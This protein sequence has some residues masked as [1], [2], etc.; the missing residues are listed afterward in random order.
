MEEATVVREKMGSLSHITTIIAHEIRNPL[1]GLNIYLSSLEDILAKQGPIDEAA[2][3]RAMGIVK[4]MRGVS[5]KIEDIVRGVLELSRPVPAR[6]NPVQLNRA[7]L[8]AV[9]LCQRF[10]RRGRIRLET[11]LA[12]KSPECGADSILVELV[13]LNLVNNAAQALETVKREK[14]VSIATRLTDSHGVI[15]VEDSGPGVPRGLRE[16]IFDPVFT[17]KKDGLGIGLGFCRRVAALHSGFLEVCESPLGGAAFR[18]GIPL[19]HGMAAAP[20]EFA[21]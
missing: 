5:D 2:R 10:L 7:V 17:T 12:E 19:A 15:S 20:P 21:L 14:T 6:L 13:L 4:T 1:S 11:N 8:D 18:F 16:R 3:E 9:P